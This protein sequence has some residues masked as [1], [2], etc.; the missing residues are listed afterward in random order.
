MMS[1]ETPPIDMDWLNECTD[2]D[3]DALKSMVE[4]YLTRTATLITELDGAVAA[5]SAEE[6]RRIAH[7]CAGSSGTCGMAAMV[8]LF[9]SLEKMGASS[10]L[11]NAA[12]VA[13]DVRREFERTRKFVAEHGLC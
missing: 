5:R 3:A 8:P 9:R 2:G 1:A 6:I 11:E 12:A 4:L 10:Q 7:A 13:A